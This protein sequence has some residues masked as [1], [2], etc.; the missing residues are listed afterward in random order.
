MAEGA[1]TRRPGDVPRANKGGLSEPHS[2]LRSGAR[3]RGI[4]GLVSGSVVVVAMVL[5]GLAVPPAAAVDDTTPPVGTLVLDSGNPATNVPNISVDYTATD[6]LSGVAT[7]ELSNDGEAWAAF[8]YPGPGRWNITDPAFG[9]SSADGVH[10]VY[11]RWTDGAGNTSARVS[12]TIIYDATPPNGTLTINDGSGATADPVLTLHVGATDTIGVVDV[13][14]LGGGP[15][16]VGGTFPYAPTLTFS[17]GTPVSDGPYGIGA[18]WRDLAGNAMTAYASIALDRVA[19]VLSTLYMVGTDPATG[20]LSFSFHASDATEILAARF[21][22]NGGGTWGPTVPIDSVTRAASYDPFA[23]SGGGGPTLGPRTLSAQV[24][25]AAGN[26]S[27]VQS[28]P[29]EVVAPITIGVSENPTTGEPLTLSIEWSRAVVLPSGSICRWEFLWGDDESINYGNRNETFGYLLIEGPASH[30]FCDEW[31]FTLPW[32]PVR[33]YLV[34][35]FVRTSDWFGLGSATIGGGLGETA[36]SST[37]G[38]T[39]RHI[40]T[41]NLPMFYVLPDAYELQVGEPAVYRAY[42]VGGATIKS[43]DTW[44]IQYENVPERHPGSTTLTFVPK[45]TGNLTVC[46]SRTRG[47]WIASC[48]DPPVRAPSGGGGSGSTATAAPATGSPGPTADGTTSPAPADTSAPASAP[49]DVAAAGP[50]SEANAGGPPGE[51][52]AP[53][54]T[55]AGWFAVVLVLVAVSTLGGLAITRP[56]FRVRAIERLRGLTR[57]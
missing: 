35:A 33:R 45:K 1:D 41:S 3:A 11:A 51:A 54:A 27:N 18:T 19:P 20:L 38:S 4:S 36:F 29:I 47:D 24:Q 50:T 7:V 48:F 8:G 32:T 15:N 28:I 6:D 26:W 17:L 49:G 44:E 42:A 13:E 56:T 10:A 34:T 14:V 23:T 53:S 25:D 16:S 43:T 37:V 12:K 55:G 52:S 22:V 57:R 5:A 2:L 40:K 46:L 9:G 21:S 39:S 30:G 31:T